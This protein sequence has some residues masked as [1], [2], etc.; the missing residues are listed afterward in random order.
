[1]NLP[2]VLVAVTVA[3]ALLL[4]RRRDAAVCEL[5]PCPECASCGDVRGTVYL[6]KEGVGRTRLTFEVR[7]LAPGMHGAHVHAHGD[8]RHGCAGTCAHH[9]PDGTSHGGPVGP[10]R[11]RGDLGN[12]VADPSGESDTVVVVD[13]ALHELVGR[14]IIVHAGPDDLGRG[15]NDESRKTGNAGARVAGGLIR[16]LR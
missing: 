1:M 5:A 6:Q 14:T 2:V 16:W 9:N 11:H 12:I 13:T 7:G 3:V 4:L 8:L 15:G 10:R